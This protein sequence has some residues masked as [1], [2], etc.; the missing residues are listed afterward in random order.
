MASNRFGLQCIIATYQGVRKLF[1]DFKNLHPD[2]IRRF[3][4]FDRKHLPC[5][6]SVE[7]IYGIPSLKKPIVPADILCGL[8]VL[9]IHCAESGLVCKLLQFS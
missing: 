7:V 6:E 5:L 4:N 1:C 9:K 3:L 2:V 8:S